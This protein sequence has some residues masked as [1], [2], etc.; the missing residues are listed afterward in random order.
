MNNK[1][2]RQLWL[3]IRIWLVAVVTNAVLGSFFLAD[4]KFKISTDY[5]Q[6][7]LLYGSI[8]SLPVLVAL[9]YL[10]KHCVDTNKSGLQIFGRVITVSILATVLMFMCFW[11]LIGIGADML[12]LSLLGIAL[13]SGIIAI[14]IQYR[15]F[16]K[17]GSDF[18]TIQTYSHE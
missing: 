8:F 18:N 9:Y 11:G 16:I 6:A 5:L 4:F 1:S 12:M 10:I 15:S 13:L 14:S 3:A 7:G 17:L 2:L